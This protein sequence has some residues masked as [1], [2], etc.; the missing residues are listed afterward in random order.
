M[1][2]KCEE[3]EQFE[4]APHPAFSHLLP[5]GE[6]NMQWLGS[7]AIR[8][9]IEGPMVFIKSADLIGVE[10]PFV[11]FDFINVALPWEFSTSVDPDFDRFPA[12][13]HFSITSLIYCDVILINDPSVVVVLY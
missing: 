13:I 9:I 5:D 10:R 3:N 1:N 8:P 6:G 2:G 4:V 7:R 12:S 11:E